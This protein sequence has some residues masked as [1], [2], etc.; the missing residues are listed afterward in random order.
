MRTAERVLEIIREGDPDTEITLHY[1]RNLI[2]SGKIPVVYAGR[3]KLV[4][5]D[6]MID[7]IGNAYEAVPSE[8]VRPGEIRQVSI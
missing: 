3:K 5:A 4:D 1:I 7:Y 2:N 8:Q 6:K